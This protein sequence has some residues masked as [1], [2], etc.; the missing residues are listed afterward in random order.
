MSIGS[1]RLSM[2]ER[3][4]RRDSVTIESG[5]PRLE[6]PLDGRLGGIVVS[7]ADVTDFIERWRRGAG[8]VNSDAEGDSNTNG[9]P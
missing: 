3:A 5:L 2:A 4:D 9:G 6:P 8:V 1:G 7:G